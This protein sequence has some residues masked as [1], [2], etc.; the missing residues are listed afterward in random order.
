MSLCRSGGEFPTEGARMR[1]VVADENA[2][3]SFCLNVPSE[4]YT[5][6]PR[7]WWYGLHLLSEV[8]VGLDI[9]RKVF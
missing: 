3:V 6:W 9:Q 1:I 7:L 2:V 8:R 5:Y 4:E